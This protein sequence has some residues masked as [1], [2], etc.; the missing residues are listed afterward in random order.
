M[1]DLWRI[2]EV[3]V[4]AARGG[5]LDERKQ[6]QEKEEPRDEFHPK[7]E[8]I[9]WNVRGSGGRKHRKKLTTH[10][11]IAQIGFGGCGGMYNYFL[12]VASILQ[13]E[14]YDL[15]NVIFSGVSAGCFPA[16]ILALGIN[17]KEF[18]FKENIPLIEHAAACSYAGL[19]KW[20]PLVKKNMLAM[21][22]EDAYKKG[23]QK[24]YF[25]VTEVPALKNHVITTWE[26]NEDMV[27]CMLSSGHVPLYTDSLVSSYRG[28]KFVDGGLTNNHP[29]VHPTAPHAMLQIW[30]WRWISPTWILVTTNA[31]WATE[32]FRMGREDATKHLHEIERAFFPTA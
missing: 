22:P 30:K 7:I 25:S 24:L 28:K 29:I 26:S 6:Q 20:I 27:D 11:D 2:D 8:A 16:T 23:D 10:H 14:E 13:V 5:A 9:P 1:D 21:L 31:D 4:A 18:F 12:G 15:E 19:G 17:A 3:P 32:M